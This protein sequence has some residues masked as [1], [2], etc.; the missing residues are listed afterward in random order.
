MLIHNL[1][2]MKM[3][4]LFSICQAI[5]SAIARERHCVYNAETQMVFPCEQASFYTERA[6]ITD[7]FISMAS[8][9]IPVLISTLTFYHKITSSILPVWWVSWGSAT[10][11]RRPRGLMATRYPFCGAA[12]AIISLLKSWYFDAKIGILRWMFHYGE[13]IRSDDWAK[14]LIHAD[15]LS[16]YQEYYRP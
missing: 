12:D 1:D 3:R 7:K 16:L 13:S 15:E 2:P 6:W 10:I 14:S 11:S 8:M 9:R 5:S 4:H